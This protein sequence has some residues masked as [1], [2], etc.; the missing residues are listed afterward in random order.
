MKVFNSK[1]EDLINKA[2]LSWYKGETKKAIKFYNLALKE[3][4]AGPITKK[5]V[6][7]NINELEFELK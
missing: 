3:K 1:Y 4:Q 5:S 2:E 6:R 7:E